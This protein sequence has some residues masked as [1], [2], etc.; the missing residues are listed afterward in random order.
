MPRPQPRGSCQW[1]AGEIRYP[2][3]HKRAGEIDKRNWH[4]ECVEKYRVATQSQAQR[5]ACLKRDQ[6]RCARCGVLAVGIRFRRGQT[7]YMQGYQTG[8]YCRVWPVRD[9]RWDADHIRPLWSAPADMTLADRGLWFG[10]ENLQTLCRPC[11]KSKSAREAK[12]RTD[13]NRPGLPLLR[14]VA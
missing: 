8:E 2:D 5:E 1:C 14:C 11:H 9:D 3:S 12:E 13:I 6:G 4:P 10:L 7:V